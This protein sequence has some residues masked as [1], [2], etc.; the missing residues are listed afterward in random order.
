MSQEINATDMEL[1]INVKILDAIARAKGFG[2]CLRR[3]WAVAA[4]L[5]DKEQSLPTLIPTPGMF[6][7]PSHSLQ[8]RE[9]EQCTFD[10]C[11][12]SRVDFTS[13][14][15]RHEKRYCEIEN[16]GHCGQRQF[17]LN[18]GMGEKNAAVWDLEGRPLLNSSHPYM[19]ISHVWADGTGAG[20][21]G[22]GKCEGCWW[23]I[24]SIPK[25]KTA[26]AKA[27]NN[28]QSN[29]A[30]ARITLVHD[31]YLRSWEWVDAEKACFAIVMSPWYSR[32]WTALELAKSHKVKI[33][34]K[35]RNDG[36]VIKDLDVDILAEIKPSSWYHDTAES[37]RKLRH[38]SIQSLNDLLTILKPRDTSK[39]RDVPII[40]G[41]LAGVH[42][43]GRLSQQEIYQ[44]IL[45]KLGKVAQGHLFHKSATMSSPG[46]S[47]C[48]TNILE[49]PQAEDGDNQVLKLHENGDLEGVWKVY[50]TDKIESDELIW[51]GTHDLTKVSLKSALKGKD[52]EKNVLLVENGVARN[53][54]LLVKLMTD[55]QGKA[56]CH[57]IGPVYF[58]PALLK[59]KG[60]E[61]Y[62][63]VKFKIG[64]TENMQEL[65]GTAWDFLSLM[66]GKNETTNQASSTEDV[67]AAN[68]NSR[69]EAKDLEGQTTTDPTETDKTPHAEL[70][71]DSLGNRRAILY[72]DKKPDY[73]LFQ[74]G[75]KIPNSKDSSPENPETMVLYYK[76]S[77]SSQAFFY[78]QKRV[79]EKIKEWLEQSQTFKTGRLM[80]LGVDGGNIKDISDDESRAAGSLAHDAIVLLIQTNKTDIGPLVE[81]LLDNK[82]SHDVQ[83]DEQTL[84]H[85]ALEQESFEIVEKLLTNKTNPANPD[86]RA[87]DMQIALHLTA[88]KAHLAAEEYLLAKGAQP[89][90][91]KFPLAASGPKEA[92]VTT[93]EARVTTEEAEEA[94]LAAEEADKARL[95]EN[96]AKLLVEK[97]KDINT[98]EPSMGQ[99]ALH[100]AAE[101]GNNVLATSLIG[102]G[103]RTDIKDC[104]RHK[105]LY[106]AAKNNRD[107][108]VT[109]LLEH[110]KDERNKNRS[111][112]SS[113]NDPNGNSN[114]II[115]DQSNESNK[116]NRDSEWERDKTNALHVVAHEGHESI[117]N[118]I[119]QHGANASS[120]DENGRT[121][122][123]LA[124]GA[125]HHQVVDILIRKRGPKG[126]EQKE[127][128]KEEDLEKLKKD[129]QEEL[130]EAL[131]LAVK[132]KHKE[133][134]R[135]L[136][137][138]GAKSD[139][140]K[141]EEMTALHLTIEAGDKE[142][143]KL[144]I[145][146]LGDQDEVNAQDHRKKQ[147]AL[148]LAADKGMIDAVAALLDK[149][150]DVKLQ[151]LY[152]R[153]ALHWAV[154]RGNV[155]IMEL[156]L[157]KTPQEF[158]N[159]LDHDN[160][161]SLHWAVCQGSI[162]AMEL[163]LKHTPQYDAP[164][165]DGR[166]ALILAAERGNIEAVGRLLAIG[167]SPGITDKDEMTA[168]D[169]ATTNGHKA[170]VLRLLDKTEKDEA[171]KKALDL[172]V[173]KGHLPMAMEIQKRIKDLGLRSSALASILFLASTTPGSTG[174]VH[175]LM[176]DNSDLNQQD[177][178]KGRTALMLSVESEND[179]FAL[180]LL[181]LH[182]KTDL[183]D[184]DGKTALM[185][186]TKS[187]NKSIMEALLKAKADANIQDNQG[188]TSLH[189]A[190]ESNPSPE[191]LKL[192]LELGKADPN[193]Q[194][195]R[196]RT[197]LH[198]LLETLR[199]SLDSGTQFSLV[200]FKR[201][202]F[203]KIIFILLHN[204][205]KLELKD[206]QGQ[207]PLH[208]AAHIDQS[209]AIQLLEHLK[210][211][212]PRPN[213]DI[214]DG[215]GRSPLLLAAERGD[216][217]LVKQLLTSNLKPDTQNSRGETPLLFA[218][219]RG[220]TSIVK[221]L[222]EKGAD[223]N[224]QDARGRTPLSQAAQNGKKE[225]VEILLGT[226][227]PESTLNIRDDMGRTALL[228]AAENGHL[229][230]V[231]I[232]HSS[233]ANLDLMDYGGK[234]A[235]QKA[236]D[237][238]HIDIVKYLLS[239]LKR[240]ED[241]EGIND[242]QERHI[243]DRE[244]RDVVDRE[245]RDI[246]EAL[247][248]ASRTGWVEL[249]E[250]LLDKEADKTFQDCQGSTALHLATMSGHQEVVNK[251][252][253]KG[254]I[255]AIE[256]EKGHT[257]LMQ[258]AE[259][260]FGSIVSLLLE[261]GR[262]KEDLNGWK[263]PEVLLFAAEKGDTKIVKLLLD[264]NVNFNYVNS[265]SQTAMA[266]AAA[267]GY[268]AIVELLL[269]RKADS[270]IKDNHDRTALHHAAWGGYDDVV[271][272]LLGKKVDLGASDNLGQLA[273]H[274]AAERA[275][276]KVVEKLL[277]KKANANKKSNDGQTALH[278][279]AW[280]GSYEVVRLLLHHGGDPFERDNMK[281]RP[282][283]V[284]A[285]KGH[286]SIVE[287]LLG[288]EK[289]V[290]E[291]EISK[292]KGLIFAAKKGY[293]GI[294]RSLLDRGANVD[295]RDKEELTPLHW[296]MKRGDQE[297]VNLLVE[298]ILVEER[299]A[300]VNMRDKKRQTPL[301][302]GVLEK[303]A[304]VVL[305]L[306]RSDADANIADKDGRTALHHAAQNGNLE[307]VQ[308]L[309]DHKADPHI[310]DAET[311]KA[312]ELAADRGHN[313]IVDL[314]L[315][316]ELDLR[317]TSQKMERLLL[318]MAERGWVPMVR[319]LLKK[320]VNSNAEDHRGRVPIGIA[321][322]HGKH[323]VV[324]LLLS[325]GANPCIP[326][327]K[328]Q[329]PILWAAE[330]GNTKIIS[331]LL[332]HF[333]SNE[334]SEKAKM[335][336]HCDSGNRTALL[337]ALEKGHDDVAGLLLRKGCAG[338]EV[339]H[340]DI[341]GRTA[342]HLAAERGNLKLVQLLLDK[343]A[344]LELQDNLNQTALLL[345]AEQGKNNV[346]NALL[347]WLSNSTNSADSIKPSELIDK[348]DRRD[349]TA[350]LIAAER[351]DKEMVEKLLDLGANANHEDKLKRT[352]L[353]LAT[354][355]GGKEVVDLLLRKKEDQQRKGSDERESLRVAVANGDKVLTK[356][357]LNRP[358]RCS[359]WE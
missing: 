273:L 120:R 303:R 292:E 71:A 128:G 69:S 284:A 248:L 68:Q 266:L 133:A 344:D 172:A 235:W 92:G 149:Q 18:N 185:M 258:A 298:N 216:D 349:R 75:N 323:D 359:K 52:E 195:N 290:G 157:G 213:L 326:D 110:A 26:R 144:L 314:L 151:D 277:D 36:Y 202:Q 11:E 153:T 127:P 1:G 353:T 247:L 176:N 166:T 336:N 310:R 158:I 55:K 274:L 302:L 90:A 84:L 14:A 236:M 22:S 135:K 205:A 281:N 337:I 264:S 354:E 24:I 220:D 119:L 62:T 142:S 204:Q 315:E 73:M 152:N 174:E 226:K 37:I 250:V 321:A 224:L 320:G 243:I 229:E 256:D 156:L 295:M 17:A 148:H 334:P 112:N 111:D 242:R 343:G 178:K 296:A 89:A 126:S 143:S 331:S 197:A 207:T 124:A 146:A 51:I 95:Y 223:R 21:W 196:S 183:Q 147:S 103:A 6:S 122:L 358:A 169:R 175:D 352:A 64:S 251:L 218:A 318:Q 179:Q 259:H 335:V 161:T 257:A 317:P 35:A 48:P 96:V 297:L 311:K 199:R 189:Y 308:I 327:S 357:L 267:N 115:N 29:Y 300:T 2:L 32:G 40:S 46:F 117:V 210:L 356:T 13:V 212:K 239:D 121:A 164:D 106:H 184:N 163:I 329:T 80:L 30:D 70:E 285:E 268:K 209:I 123:M 238:K 94:R 254:S 181:K 79:G 272:I 265:V 188:Y 76:T 339:N 288:K 150:A 102:K 237:N 214:E 249:V 3:I 347:D 244:R 155:K 304:T 234:K 232:L 72:L 159:T 56:C 283:Q 222:L 53:R 279:A 203:R 8:G 50:A 57:S 86:T 275:S 219:K 180:R 125:G 231:E 341:T 330:A 114:R 107:K 16:H 38:A 253:D 67:G 291:E 131:L 65:T 306:L 260:G 100:L 287:A 276:Q 109:A 154:I 342:L 230:I 27:L 252:L 338:I 351:G 228:H 138:V 350:L 355:N 241:G 134:I 282:W 93:E 34:F 322:E 263:G 270:T 77:E 170:V 139:L 118:I 208:L 345:A 7:I 165:K 9:H 316:K 59:K 261:K 49:M 325:E 286:E 47:W 81:L 101:S 206:D 23:D 132:G 19:A 309:V 60:V 25:D 83:D 173:E 312:W 98:K 198:L 167:S 215:E 33:L 299:K 129:K 182:A 200:E 168:L 87:A 255:F 74:D 190:T 294:A 324:K 271:E 63:G 113:G 41:I 269:E 227:K 4:S 192:L 348:T 301:L 319:L 15:Q 31:L 5:P 44:R 305:A 85:L 116:N 246:S 293:V 262:A 221:A 191:S 99:T 307:I 245:R 54:A 346:V 78:G 313:L 160:R 136:Q 193:T 162:E 82:A 97:T 340:K 105:A 240:I 28:M 328:R 130:N 141:S 233:G 278:R 66:N 280:G 20:T 225:V 289:D 12:Q 104:D 201:R 333:A 140:L 91:R 43:D 211:Q 58:D 39:P 145:R 332:H 45:R 137:D 217:V 194:D 10:F 171:R 61:S 187:E 177:K 88:R 108:I 186:A 42:V